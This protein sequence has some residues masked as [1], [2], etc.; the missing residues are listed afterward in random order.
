LLRSLIV[1]GLCGSIATGYVSNK[2]TYY[3]YGAMRN[4]NNTTKPHDENIA[5]RQQHFDDNVWAGLVELLNDP[6]NRKA[7]LERRLERKDIFIQRANPDHADTDKNLDRLSIQEQRI[8][9]AYREGIITL[10]ELK[11]QKDAIVNKR[12]VLEAKKKAAISQSEVLVQ[13]EITMDMLE[14]VSARFSRAMANASFDK[15]QKLANRLINSVTLHPGRAVIEGNIPI[16]KGDALIPSNLWSP[17]IITRSIPADHL[18]VMLS[19]LPASQ[20]GRR[21]LRQTFPLSKHQHS[22]IR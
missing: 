4:N 15:R 14:D 3:S 21:L 7:Q 13:P 11:N 5:V 2:K 8:L 10:D 6:E 20:P 1:C 16:I 19:G 9:D 18:Q 22:Y 17:I 12:K